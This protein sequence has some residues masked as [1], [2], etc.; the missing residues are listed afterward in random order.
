MPLPMVHLSIAESMLRQKGL[1]INASFLLGSI[2]P[3][4]IHMREHSTR[5]DKDRTHFYLKGDTVLVDVFKN[6]LMPYFEPFRFDEQRFWFA[7]GYTAHVLTDL[8]WHQSVYRDFQSS[9]AQQQIKNERAL[10]DMET[11]QVDFHLYKNEAWRPHV[12]ELLDQSVSMD[13]SGLLTAEE[14]QNWKTR[15]LCWFTDLAKEPGIEPTYI[16]GGVVHQFIQ[17]T[18][19]QLISLFEQV[20]YLL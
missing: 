20:D 9:I 5:E 2:A 17:H 15:T 12:W 13:A 8:M 14:V 18:S 7:R 3:D 16:T 4:A 19:R 6:K 11:D 10:Y 1:D